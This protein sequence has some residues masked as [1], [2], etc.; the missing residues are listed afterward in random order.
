MDR[1]LNLVPFVSVDHMLKL[2]LAIGVEPFLV[3]L[4][5]YVEADFRRWEAFDKTARVAA[6]SAE[7]VIELMPASDDK[8]YG[9]KYVNGHPGNTRDG[10]QTVTAFGVLADVA[11][12]YPLLLS[13]MT[14]L[15]ALRTAA[16]SALA[17]RYLA[18]PGARTMAIIGKSGCQRLCICPSCSQ[19]F[20]SRSNLTRVFIPS[21]LNCY[22]YR[23]T[24]IASPC[25]PR[26]PGEGWGEGNGHC[27]SLFHFPGRR[28]AMTVKFSVPHR[29]PQAASFSGLLFKR[30]QY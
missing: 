23:E 24:R 1:K 30:V 16:T 9:F 7:G 6:H 22:D 29:C 12:G 17:A 14:L 10:R 11:T 3:A 13:E 5:G 25:P 20:L 8:I 4:A 26:P 18:P 27:V 28:F 15:T 21:L 19:G 2:V